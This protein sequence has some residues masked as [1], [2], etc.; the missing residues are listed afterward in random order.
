MTVDRPAQVSFMGGLSEIVRKINS[1]HVIVHEL[2]YYGNENVYNK[3]KMK[4]GLTNKL[5]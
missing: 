3:P 5:N 2:N 1:N 4:I